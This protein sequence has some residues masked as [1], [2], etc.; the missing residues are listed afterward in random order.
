MDKDIADIEAV[1]QKDKE[2]FTQIIYNFA[3]PN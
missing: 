3:T 2:Y 1:I